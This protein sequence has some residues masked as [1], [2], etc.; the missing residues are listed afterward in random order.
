MTAQY[1]VVSADT[2]SVVLTPVND[3]DSCAGCGGNCAACSVRFSVSNGRHLTVKP[4]QKVK[5]G[6]SARHEALQ[7]IL[8]L[9]FPVVCAAG[10]FFAAQ[11]LAS[12]FGKK[13][14]EGMHAFCVLFFLAAACTVVLLVTRKRPNPEKLEITE[15]C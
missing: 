8:S 15:I 5:I 12:L 3:A 14:S 1:I 6:M 9:A 10:G 7:G 11:P 4:G 13:A 2:D